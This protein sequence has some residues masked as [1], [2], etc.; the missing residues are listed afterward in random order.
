[1]NISGDYLKL[2]F[3]S[4][5]KIPENYLNYAFCQSI[6]TLMNIIN[7]DFLPSSIQRHEFKV[8][9]Y[10]VSFAKLTIII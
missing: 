6:E 7:F 9:Q 10:C 1:M 3:S 4:V 2:M 8:F 5:K